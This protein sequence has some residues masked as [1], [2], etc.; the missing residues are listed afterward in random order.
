MGNGIIVQVLKFKDIQNF[1]S[2]FQQGLGLPLLL[3]IIFQVFTIIFLIYFAVSWLHP[4]I[5][6]LEQYNSSF[7][8]NMNHLGIL[9]KCTFWLNRA[10]LGPGFC[11]PNKLPVGAPA[12]CRDKILDIWVILV[13]LML[14]NTYTRCSRNSLFLG[15]DSQIL[16]WPQI[17]WE[18]VC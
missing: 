5:T 4:R 6:A 2:P 17:M 13:C 10:G 9:S 1:S 3:W 15:S 11:I 14:L 12:L 8:V 16:A 7:N 18:N